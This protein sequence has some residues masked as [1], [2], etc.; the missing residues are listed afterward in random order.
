MSDTCLHGLPAADCLIC[1]TLGVAPSDSGRGGSAGAGSP[2]VAIKR[3]SRRGGGA[4]VSA[5]VPAVQPDTVYPSGAPPG[6]D[7]SGRTGLTLVGAI[8]ALLAIGAVVWVIF[9]VVFTLLHVLELVVVAVIAG[10]LG[11]RIGHYRG[12]HVRQ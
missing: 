3:R 6:R 9:S 4:P 12:R 5:G 7:R 11:Y 10:W 1:R 8:L 2:A